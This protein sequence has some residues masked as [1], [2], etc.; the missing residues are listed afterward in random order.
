MG[1]FAGIGVPMTPEFTSNNQSDDDMSPRGGRARRIAGRVGA[2]EI[3]ALL[4]RLR[5]DL[6]LADLPAQ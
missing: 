2:G 4:L 6:G 3:L 1:W 5:T